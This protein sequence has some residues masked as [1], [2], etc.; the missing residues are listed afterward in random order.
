[1]QMQPDI[2]LKQV[3]LP[4]HLLQ[5]LLALLDSAL[6]LLDTFPRPSLERLFP[7]AV[8][9]RGCKR[10]RCPDTL[11]FPSK[12]DTT[13]MYNNDNTIF[14][15]EINDQD[16]LPIPQIPPPL[17]QLRAL[18]DEMAREQQVVLGRD[19]EGVAHERRAVDDEGAGHLAG[20]SNSS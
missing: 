2:Y 15:Q 7:A 10:Q 9:T 8:A 18:V 20:D 1:M 19:G 3:S 6:C 12:P 11:F 16:S 14:R 5:L 4:R 17:R 13:A